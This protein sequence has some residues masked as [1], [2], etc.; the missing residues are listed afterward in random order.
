VCILSSNFKTLVGQVI[1]SEVEGRPIHELI[2]EIGQTPKLLIDLGFPDLAF[3]VKAKTIGKIYFDHGIK[4]SV[5][6]RIPE[7]VANPQAIFQSATNP[8]NGVI[9]TYELKGASPVIIAVHRDKSVGRGKIVNELVSMYGK[10]GPDPMAKWK[11]KGL[12]LW[13]K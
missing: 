13:E 11:E 5:I 9:V 2:L 1:R 7:I 4:Q 6:E 12:L 8:I 3:I 10:E